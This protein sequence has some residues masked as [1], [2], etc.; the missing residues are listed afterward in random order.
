MKTLRWLCVLVPLLVPNPNP[1]LAYFLGE[2]WADQIVGAQEGDWLHPD[3]VLCTAE[4]WSKAETLLGFGFAPPGLCC[5]TLMWTRG[6]ARHVFWPAPNTCSSCWVNP[7][8]LCAF[9]RPAGPDERLP[10]CVSDHINLRGFIWYAQLNLTLYTCY[11]ST[12]RVCW[13]RLNLTSLSD[14]IPPLYKLFFHSFRDASTT[15]RK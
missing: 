12:S 9:R 5:G 4:E 15:T 2:Q 14:M 13:L 3:I 6:S 10:E 8:G 1:S 11:K 7:S